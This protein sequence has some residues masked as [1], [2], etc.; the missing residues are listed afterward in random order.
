M[1]ENDDNV[2]NEDLERLVNEQVCG[3]ELRTLKDDDFEH[4]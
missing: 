1:F 3:R 2:G 4:N